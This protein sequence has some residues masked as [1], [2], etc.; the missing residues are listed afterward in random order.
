MSEER[1]RIE[2][3]LVK[4]LPDYL[5]EFF[6][7]TNPQEATAP[8][9]LQRAESMARNPSAQDS[10]VGLLVA[11][12]GS[13]CVGY[14]GVLP[15]LLRTETGR[16]PIYW[17][18]GGFVLPQY[19]NRMLAVLLTR[20]V[21]A[22][23]RDVVLTAYSREVD[24]LFQ[25][26]GFQEF[27][28][29]EYLV[30]FVK[31][32]DVIGL[33]LRRAGSRLRWGTP[34][35]A[36]RRLLFSLWVSHAERATEASSSTLKEVD[37]LCPFAGEEPSPPYF[38]RDTDSINWML[39]YPWIV[40][41]G[42]ESV[43]PYYFRDIRDFFRYYAYEIIDNQGCYQGFGVFSVQSE[44]GWTTVKLTDYGLRKPQDAGL[45]FHALVRLCALHQAD[46]IEAPMML[47][48]WL[49][50]LPAAS[51]LFRTQRRYYLGYPGP[52]G[53]LGNIMSR[54]SLRYSDSDCAFA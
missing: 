29:Y 25:K 6:A 38:E 31:K 34:Y 47:S 21:Q 41:G 9:S 8:M 12:V 45:L 33:G 51:Y 30:G 22:L 7:K 15:G 5:R 39:S 24:L 52:S 23:K 35:Q 53:C 10:D 49:S 40:S 2:K 44:R 28:P 13:A 17:C 48:S 20:A 19:R 11:Y 43:P 27:G 36:A 46:H 18:S 50:Q 1:P 16:I 37:Q 32:L 42:Q 54:I 3:V 14:Q 4:Q 26:L